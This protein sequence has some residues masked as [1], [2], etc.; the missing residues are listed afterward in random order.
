MKQPDYKLI[1][2]LSYFAIYVIWGSNFI[3]I[4]F[5][6]ES[7]PPFLMGGI[8]FF[9]AGAMLFIF[10]L[11]RNRNLPSYTSLLPSIKQ[12][13]W[14]NFVGTGALIWS[15]QYVSTG[16]AS[17]IVTTV[18]VWMILMDTRHI[19]KN[20]SNPW[21]TLALLVGI[22]GVVLL[23][24][25]NH[26]FEGGSSGTFYVGL[27]VLV[28]GTLGWSYGSIYTKKVKSTLPLTMNLAIQM[29]SAGIF[30]LLFSTL[31]NEPG[32]FHINQ[33]STVSWLA[34]LY[35]II[36][37]SILSYGAYLWL[38]KTRPIVEVSTYSF[39]NPMVA[40]VLGV[41]LANEQINFETFTAMLLILFAVFLIKYHHKLKR[42]Y[43]K[44][45]IFNKN[46]KDMIARTWHGKVP[47]EK[48]DEY[49][50]YLQKTGLSDYANI[51][52]NLGIKVLRRDEKQETHFMLITYWESIEAIKNFAG[53]DYTRARYY[54]EDENFLLEFEPVYHYEVLE[55]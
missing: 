18:P 53:D 20:I 33:V 31:L 30:F 55:T 35:M 28:I 49:F 50:A 17:L 54:K 36:F 51:K 2:I 37:G 48:G 21:I 1:M 40:I 11:I 5:G 9:L 4:Y 16:F 34:L 3:S 8:R 13:F 15:E 41:W 39:V 46:N 22:S 14:L 38:V 6:L 44:F 32:R 23:T 25:S 10:V 43:H 47:K 27:L 26:D 42:G 12:G 52:G 45:S 7:F 24:V 29:L 19:K